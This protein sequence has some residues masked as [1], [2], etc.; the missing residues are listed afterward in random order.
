MRTPEAGGKVGLRALQAVIGVTMALAAPLDARAEPPHYRFELVAPKH[1]PACNDPEG[2]FEELDLALSQPLLDPPASRVLEVHIER[3][4]G[5]AYGVKVVFREPG[6]QVLETVRLTYP[7]SMECFKVLHKVA[8]VAAI[9]MEAE[10]G[11]PEEPT[12]PPPPPAAPPPASRPAPP[13]EPCPPP[14]PA[15]PPKPPAARRGFVGAGLGA[16]L[17]FAPEAFFAPRVIVGWHVRP[18][19]VLELDIAG[20]AWMTANPQNG[21]TAVDVQ[22]GLGT[23]A[24]CYAPSSLRLCG[25]IMGGVQRSVGNERAF[26]QATTRSLFGVGLRAG[27]EQVMVG[28]L[29]LRTDLDAVFN[30]AGRDIYGQTWPLWE[31]IPLAAN[32]TTS[33]LWSF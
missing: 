12:P 2:F 33:L 4:A 17:G 15:E 23:L 6:G 22:T 9:E 11:A 3:P 18:R 19:L 7:G 25:F 32:V 13:S 31:P 8:L 30:L 14:P 28:S 10:E 16:F 27:F 26:S 24:G 21:P 5:G 20:Q 1:L 29:L